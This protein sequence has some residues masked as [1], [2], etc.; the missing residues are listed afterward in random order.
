MMAT[1]TTGVFPVYNNKFKIGTKGRESE[2]PTDFAIVKGMET[3]SI[4]I[5]GS[6]EEWTPMDTEGWM[7]RLMTG[8]SLTLN[9]SG[10][11][12][13]GD[14][15][16]DYIAELAWKTGRDCESVLEWEFPSGGKLVFDC[17][18]SVTEVGGGDST[19]VGSLVADLLSNGK[20]EY[21]PPETQQ[22]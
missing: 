21:T 18:V 7:E 1:V 9:L 15:G 14:P 16:N 22:G 17:V 8:K 4:S 3:F 12:V 5:D 19:G 11:R 2:S 20:P 13:Y 10:K 6:V